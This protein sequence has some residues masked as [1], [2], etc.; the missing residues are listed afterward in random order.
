MAKLIPILYSTEM[1]HANLA[2][3]KT[4]TRRSVDQSKYSI[5]E[6]EKNDG[7]IQCPY[8]KVGDILWGREA[9]QKG[10]SENGYVYRADYIQ[11]THTITKVSDLPKWRPSIHMPFDAARIFQRIKDI[12]VQRLLD[13]TEEDAIAEGIVKVGGDGTIV[14]AD[15]Y[16]TSDGEIGPWKTARQ[17]Y[18]ALWDKING[19]YSHKLNPWVWAISYEMISKEEAL[20][21]VQK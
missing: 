3:I 6:M 4:Q 18:F 19:A 12:R 8:G 11:S 21:H 1:V 13:I 5:T 15:A 2:G 7:N 14:S 17:A 16:T 9:I 20:K 10:N